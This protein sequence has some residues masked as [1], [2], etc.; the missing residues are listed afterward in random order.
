M[1][2][3]YKVLILLG[4]YSVNF[5]VSL[6]EYGGFIFNTRSGGRIKT[7]PGHSNIEMGDRVVGKVFC[8]IFILNG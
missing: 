5:Y 7:G 2:I 1:V 6:L 8:N 4:C 3:D